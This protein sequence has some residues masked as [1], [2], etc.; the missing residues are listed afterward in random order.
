M[1][2]PDINIRYYIWHYKRSLEYH[3]NKIFYNEVNH[4]RGL[5]I[6]YNAILNLPFIN[7]NYILDIFHKIKKSCIKN[8]YN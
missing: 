2:F 5:Y 6:Y 4:N 7:P 3:K 8:N 1:V